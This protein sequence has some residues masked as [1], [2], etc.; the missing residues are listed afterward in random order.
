[1]TQV[2]LDGL[3]GPSYWVRV[4][5]SLDLSPHSVPDPDLAVVTGAPRTHTANPT[6][7]LLVVEG[8]DT[9]LAHDRRI[10]GS[11][12]PA[13]GIADYWIV[14]I[15]D[16]QVQVHRDPTPDTTTPFGFRYDSRTIL[17]AG[18]LVSPLALPSGQVAVA[19]LLP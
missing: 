12:Y 2:A 8:A 19:D 11:L 6:A 3:F 1:L 13:S 5:L 9:M 10:K 15:L 14:N 16:R 17:V 18:D 4:Q 7:A